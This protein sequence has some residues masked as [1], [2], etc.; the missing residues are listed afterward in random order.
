MKNNLDF[1]RRFEMAIPVVLAPMGGGPST[2]ELTAAVSN[3]GGLGSLAA[4]YSSPERI[5]QDIARVRELTSRPFAVNLFSPSRL[6]QPGN[7]DPVTAFLRPYHERLGLKPPE[8][9]SKATED[10]DQQIEAIA[11]AAPPIVSFTFGLLPSHVTERLKGQGIYLIGTATTVE[12]ARQLERAGVDA[13]VAQGSEAG[14]HRGTFAVEAE[15]ALIGTVAL[16][17]QVVDAVNLP[18]IASGG[19]MDGRGIVAAL[20]LGASAVQM[21]TAFLLCNEAGTSAPYREALRKGH[22]DQTTLTRAFSGKM[23]RGLRNE[24]IDRWNASGL[25]HL[26]YPWQNAFTQ[27]MRRAAAQAKQSGV[28]SLWAGQGIGMIREGSAKELMSQ[29]QE[30][31]KQTCEKLG[32]QAKDEQN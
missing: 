26:P 18:V 22:E 31:V 2:P 27:S 10:F 3:A 20:A 9:P 11:K 16:V 19:I 25:T 15:E 28:L 24:F 17:P 8:L 32:V 6:P 7:P 1:R 23:A 12:E 30:E 4:A 5:Q 29:L 14:A 13:V 21:G